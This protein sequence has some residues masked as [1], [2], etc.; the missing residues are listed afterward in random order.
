M[1]DVES[2]SRTACQRVVNAAARAI[3][4]RGSFLIVVAGGKTPRI[5]YHLLCGADTDWSKWRVYFGDER[6]LPADDGERNSRMATEAW[7]SRVPIPQGCVHSI[8]AE[9]GAKPAARDYAQ[10]LAGIGD[11]D[12][13]LLGLGADG[14]TASLFPG[15]DLGAAPDAPDVLAILDSPKPPAQRVSLSASR[16][17]RARDALFLVAGESKRGAVA[18]WRAGAEIPARAI[19][20]RTSVEVLVESMLL[21]R[22]HS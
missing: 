3:A 7:L 13:V 9:R 18:R 15:H 10:T 19:R 21:K 14:H 22:S 12:L 6:C 4:E 17:S 16:L 8:P 2:L 11:F 1:A 20:P 5:T